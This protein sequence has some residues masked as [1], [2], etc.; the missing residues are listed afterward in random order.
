[1]FI[2]AKS[3]HEFEDIKEFIDR[4]IKQAEIKF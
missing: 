1:M 3:Q 4:K 2:T